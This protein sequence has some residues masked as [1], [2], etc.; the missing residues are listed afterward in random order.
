M[1]SNTLIKEDLG[2]LKDGRVDAILDLENWK[3]FN[4]ETNTWDDIPGDK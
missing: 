1:T 4:P 3:Q 2:R